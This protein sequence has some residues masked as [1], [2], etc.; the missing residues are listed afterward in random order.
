MIGTACHIEG[1]DI[2]FFTCIVAGHWMR[3]L[4]L[5]MPSL[6]AIPVHSTP[7]T[8][9]LVLS[10]RD[11]SQLLGILLQQSLGMIIDNIHPVTGAL[12]WVNLETGHISSVVITLRAKLSS[13]VYCN[14]SFLWVCVFVGVGVR[15]WVCYHDNS[16]LH[17]SIL[18][19]LGL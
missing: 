18:T 10:S 6:Y 2:F 4:F 8:V 3:Y 1:H 13:A 15:L 17:A 14:R 16:K 19:K 11:L 12:W 7:T 9:E 5:Y